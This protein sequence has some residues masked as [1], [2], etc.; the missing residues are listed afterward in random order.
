LHHAF[1]RFVAACLQDFFPEKLAHFP[2]RGGHR[3]QLRSTDAGGNTK[4]RENAAHYW[5]E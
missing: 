5:N 3:R 4:R 2:R 1:S